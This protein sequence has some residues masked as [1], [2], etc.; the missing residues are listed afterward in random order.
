LLIVCLGFGPL[1]TVPGGRAT[2]HQMQMFR[3]GE[4]VTTFVPSFRMVTD[5]A[6]DELHTNLAGGPS[7]RRFSKWYCSDLKNWL[8]G[9][10]KTIS[11][12]GTQERLRFP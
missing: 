1:V 12:D 10:Y 2:I 6:T 8:A 9:K 3:D 4:R 11:P 5:L 7:E